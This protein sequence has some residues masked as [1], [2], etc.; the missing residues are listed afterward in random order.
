MFSPF[1]FSIFSAAWPQS[2]LFHSLKLS[3]TSVWSTESNSPVMDYLLMEIIKQRN[4]D[5][6]HWSCHNVRV[7]RFLFFFYHSGMWF[8]DSV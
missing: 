7:C 3:D 2:D 4:V 5:T 6:E 1:F 8:V